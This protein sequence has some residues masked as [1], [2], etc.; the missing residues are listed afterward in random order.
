MAESEPIDE[1]AI[2]SYC[3]EP[4]EE[5]TELCF[6]RHLISEHYDIVLKHCRGDKERL[7]K[8]ISHDRASF[9]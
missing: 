2:C 9:D 8:W 7:K 5:P 3:W 6:K 4:L 1:E